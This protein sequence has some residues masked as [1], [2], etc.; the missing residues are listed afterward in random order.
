MI[1]RKCEI[2]KC[3]QAWQ[4][5]GFIVPKNTEENMHP[6]CGQLQSLIGNRLSVKQL[7]DILYD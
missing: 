7:P 4:I 1:P 6:H 5:G 2:K 3:W